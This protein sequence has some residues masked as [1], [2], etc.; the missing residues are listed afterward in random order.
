MSELKEKKVRNTRKKRALNVQY[1]INLGSDINDYVNTR[2]N[3]SKAQFYKDLNLSPTA[4]ETRLRNP[5]Y[6]TVYDLI[7]ACLVLKR[8]FISPIIT[9]LKYNHIRLN[10]LEELEQLEEY[11]KENQQL[12]DRIA[13]I[14]KDNDVL[15]EYLDHLKKTN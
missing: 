8:D 11:K 9:V 13:R 12:K 10:A 4:V 6:G 3:Y 5:Y 14:E 7:E 15:H 1:G 2:P